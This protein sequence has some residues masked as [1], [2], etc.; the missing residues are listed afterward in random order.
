MQDLCYVPL[1]G[2][3]TDYSEWTAGRTGHKL[4]V[5]GHDLKETLGI[6]GRIT[7]KRFIQ[8]AEDSMQGR[9]DMNTVRDHVIPHKTGELSDQLKDYQL[10]KS[11]V[12]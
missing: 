8:Q 7:L 9:D 10:L 3:R 6:N 1:N 12:P 2:L 5:G 4:V 11:T